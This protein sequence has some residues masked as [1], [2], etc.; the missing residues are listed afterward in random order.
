MHHIIAQLVNSMFIKLAQSLAS[1]VQYINIC[2]CW[3]PLKLW[4]TMY[5][6]IIG[7]NEGTSAS[8]DSDPESSI[9]SP[10]PLCEPR[11]PTA[12]VHA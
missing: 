8:A 3:A 10:V 9:S 11:P 12:S 2:S 5:T 7:E 4:D 1:A 6:F